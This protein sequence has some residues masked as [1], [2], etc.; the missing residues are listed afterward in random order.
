MPV[1][2]EG[3]YRQPSM[4]KKKQKKKTRFTEYLTRDEVARGIKSGQLFRASYR[5][6]LFDC[7]EAYCTVPGLPHDVLIRGLQNQNRAL[8]GDTVAVRIVPLVDWFRKL[9]HGARGDGST[10]ASATVNASNSAGASDAPPAAAGATPPLPPHIAERLSVLWGSGDSNELTAAAEPWSDAERPEEVVQLLCAIVAARPQLRVSGRVV[11]LLERSPKRENVVGVLRV[12]LGA[13]MF[14]LP[15]DPKLPKAWLWP[16]HI[17]RLNKELRIEAESED[18]AHRTLVSARVVEWNAD[19]QFPT[20]EVR[21]SIGQTGAIE[22]ETAA[23]L[24]M[25]GVRWA[26]F[27]SDVLACLPKGTFRIDKLD[28]EKRRDFRKTRIF[29]IDPLTARDLDDAVSVEELGGGRLRVGVHIADV[30]SFVPVN[31][32]LDAE[33]A[34][35]GTSV[36]LVQKVVPMLPGL[37]CEQLCSLNPG[38]DRFAFSIEWELSPEGEVLSEWVGRSVICS[39]AKLAY[40]HAQSMIEGTFDEGSAPPLACGYT[41]H[42]VQGDVRALWR[43]ASRLRSARFAGGALRLDNTRMVFRLDAD[44]NPVSAVPHVQREANQLIEEFM[45]LANM[46]VAKIISDTFP[47]RAVL[48]RHQPPNPRKMGELTE[49]CRALGV[50]VDA[51]SAGALQVS[52]AALRANH[53]D[54]DIVEIVTLLATKPMMLAKYFCTGEVDNPH[55]W[56]HYALAVPEYTHFTSPIRRYPDIM[57]HRLL[58][59]ALDVRAGMTRQQA[60]MRHR[61]PGREEASQLCNHCNSARQRARAVQEGS[62][63]LFLAVMLSQ[64]PVVTHAIIVAL[65]GDKYFTVYVP[66]FG[67]ETRV[68]VSEPGIPL[69]ADW[70][71]RSGQLSVSWRDPDAPLPPDAPLDFDMDAWLEALHATRNPDGLAPLALPRALTMFAPVPVVLGAQIS[72]TLS[73]HPTGVAAR[74]YVAGMGVRVVPEATVRHRPVVAES[75][76]PPQLDL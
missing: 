3:V 33:A 51:S 25:E 57:V 70:D 68:Q 19:S 65:G 16:Q 20:V 50:R 32:A 27:G 73:G 56:L 40:S 10:T 2:Q 15:A 28:L 42:Q 66:Q 30:A 4:E 23:L 34:A 29:T 22:S 24:E 8:E 31:S 46:R 41:W 11:A 76:P 54:P 39:C 53:P 69:C 48:R 43:L 36:Y 52:L 45:L 6:N 49:A 60:A 59:A 7:K 55:E 26:P 71:G 47:D 62:S 17:R 14:L 5:V 35:R 9:H 61:L 44:G 37:L 63:R 13:A 72:A 67:L 75:V 1:T 38:V 18:V 64:N 21:S 12:G 58:S 74:L